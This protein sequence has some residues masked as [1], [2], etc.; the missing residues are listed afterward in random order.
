M[1]YFSFSCVDIDRY[2]KLRYTLQMKVT[3][4][5]KAFRYHVEHHQKVTDSACMMKNIINKYYH[6]TKKGY[7]EIYNL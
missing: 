6:L 4:I 1:F 7:I 5:Q 2:K 3:V